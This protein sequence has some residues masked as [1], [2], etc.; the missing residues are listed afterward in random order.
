MN[1]KFFNQL[2][3]SA[4]HGDSSSQYELGVLYFDGEGVTKDY[5]QALKWFTRSAERGNSSAQYELGL[6]HKGGYGTPVDPIEALK[7]FTKAAAQ[8]NSDAKKRINEIKN[9]L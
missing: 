1:K 7:W 9:K 6:M 3:I 2:L 4:I 8:G 5:K